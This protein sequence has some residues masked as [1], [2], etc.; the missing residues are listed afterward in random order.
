MA[1]VLQPPKTLFEHQGYQ[2]PPTLS[3]ETPYF[4]AF[5]WEWLVDTLVNTE[6]KIKYAGLCYLF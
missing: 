4:P 6:Y 3:E 2:Q 1:V 5:H